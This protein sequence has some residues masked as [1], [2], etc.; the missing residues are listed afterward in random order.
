MSLL[1][2]AT[3]ATTAV[4]GIALYKDYMRDDE[5]KIFRENPNKPISGDLSYDPPQ[6]RSMGN[7]RY[8]LFPH[9]MRDDEETDKATHEAAQRANETYNK[10]DGLFARIMPTGIYDILP[11]AF[12]K[13][14]AGLINWFT[15]V[16]TGVDNAA[17]EVEEVADG[18]FNVLDSRWFWVLAAVGAGFA[19]LL[20]L[21]ILL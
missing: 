3:I 19:A 12:K 6:F 7:S 13:M 20:A 5:A 9:M 11:E 17:N 10:G 21:K 4:F 18:V 14:D 8:D 1:K 15:A 16:S 2:T